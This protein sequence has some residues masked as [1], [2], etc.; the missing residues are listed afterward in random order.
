MTMM[1][2]FVDHHIRI[3]AGMALLLAVMCSPVRPTRATQTVPSPG[4]LPRNSVARNNGYRGQFAMSA[5][6][7]FGEVDSLPSD[8]KGELD[9]DIEDELTVTSSP[10]SVSFDRLPIPSPE[11][12]SRGVR[13]AVAL[14]ARPLRC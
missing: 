4:Y 13:F 5:R 6:L 2:R 9:A 1:G 14:S 10:A 3:L 7:S 8:I 11:P 12:Y